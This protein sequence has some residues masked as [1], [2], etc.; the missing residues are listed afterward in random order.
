[1]GLERGER[2]QAPRF[3]VELRIEFKHLGRPLDSFQDLSKDISAGGVFVKTS[4]G[5]ELGTELSLEIAPGPG[6]APILMRA[7]VVRVEE[8]PGATGSKA[9]TR[10]KG[11]ALKFLDTDAG[12]LSRLLNL[13]NQMLREKGHDQSNAGAARKR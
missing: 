9:T 5:L 4:V 13:A 1:M 8:E 6:A 12:E 7:E 10:T 11:M 2:R 3:P